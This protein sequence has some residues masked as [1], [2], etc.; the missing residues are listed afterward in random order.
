DLLLDAAEACG[1]EP[2]LEI[3]CVL[4]TLA[5]RERRFDRRKTRFAE[6]AGGEGLLADRGVEQAVDAVLTLDDVADPEPQ[7]PDRRPAGQGDERPEVALA[8]AR[9][10]RAVGVE[11][12]GERLERIG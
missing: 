12:V 10:V 11:D 7:Q 6:R 1:E 2:P 8:A 3:R 5:S 9:V 4:V